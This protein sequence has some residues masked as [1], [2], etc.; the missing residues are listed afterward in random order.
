MMR[1]LVV[2]LGI[3]LGWMGLIFLN[4]PLSYII[5]A[6]IFAAMYYAYKHFKKKELGYL[7][8]E[9]ERHYFLESLRYAFV[10]LSIIFLAIFYLRELN[11]IQISKSFYFGFFTAYFL[12]IC[13][14]LLIYRLLL[15]LSAR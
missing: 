12:F 6:L 7:T 5:F 10:I 8:D 14:H 9:R 2:A 3:F 13:L 11:I 4:P 15:W 1:H